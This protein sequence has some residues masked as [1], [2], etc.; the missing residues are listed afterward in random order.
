MDIFYLKHPTVWNDVTICVVVYYFNKAICKANAVGSLLL[1]I[2]SPAEKEVEKNRPIFRCL[3]SLGRS[4]SL[5][6]SLELGAANREWAV[7][8]EN[9]ASKISQQ[10]QKCSTQTYCIARSFLTRCFTKSHR[11]KRYSAARRFR[12]T[13]KCMSHFIFLVWDYMLMTD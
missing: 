12:L 5:V 11:G 2:I 1:V 13:S 7:E 10:E 9:L 4:E 6:C 8:R 3:V